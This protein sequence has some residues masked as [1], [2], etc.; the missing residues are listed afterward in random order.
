[1]LKIVVMNG[2]LYIMISVVYDIKGRIIQTVNHVL[3]LLTLIHNIQMQYIFT[4]VYKYIHI[5]VYIS[6]YTYL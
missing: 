2:Y 3:N 1:M 6:I 4:Y 5:Y